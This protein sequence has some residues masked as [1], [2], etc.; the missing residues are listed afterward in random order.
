MRK[1]TECT[2]SS[3]VQALLKLI[4]NQNFIAASMADMNY[5]ANKMPLGKLSR[6][7]LEHGFT[8]LKRLADL[9]IDPNNAQSE[10]GTDYGQAV[11][12][13]SNRYYTVIPHSFGRSR[14]PIINDEIRLRKEIDLLEVCGCPTFEEA[15]H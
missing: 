4:F 2:L 10:Y 6:R 11:Q 12:D 9:I 7:T 15:F 14:P 1:I 3:P 13:L 5:D 8:A